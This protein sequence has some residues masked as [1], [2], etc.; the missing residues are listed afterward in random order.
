MVLTGQTCLIRFV[1][2][3]ACRC[4]ICQPIRPP[5]ERQHSTCF[6]GPQALASRGP[7]KSHRQITASATNHSG[8]VQTILSKLPG[9]GLHVLC[10]CAGQSR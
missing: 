4:S 5:L 1:I 10:P 6:K 3:R 9:K 7:L 8:S 2:M